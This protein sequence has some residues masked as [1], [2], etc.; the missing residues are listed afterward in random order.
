MATPTEFS[1][2]ACRCGHPYA[3]HGESTLICTVESCPCGEFV[4]SDKTDPKFIALARYRHVIQGMA[5]EV[6]S[7]LPAGAVVSEPNFPNLTKAS[8]RKFFPK[9]QILKAALAGI[10]AAN[11]PDMVVKGFD[12]VMEEAFIVLDGREYRMELKIVS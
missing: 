3:Q 6:L 2:L 7:S 8:E 12:L 1:D 11:D 10:K 4:P 5:A 9:V